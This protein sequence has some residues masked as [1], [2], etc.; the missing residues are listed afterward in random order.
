MV[1]VFLTYFFKESFFFKAI[2]I[3]FY[4]VIIII[5]HTVQHVES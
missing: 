3:V 4:S 2:F 1:I 5:G